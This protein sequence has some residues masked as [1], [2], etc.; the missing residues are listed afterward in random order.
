M[1]SDPSDVA[2]DLGSAWTLY[3]HDPDDRDWTLESYSRVCTVY[4]ASE[5]WGVQHRLSENNAICRGMW[6]L[7]REDVFP[8]WDDASNIEGGCVSFMVGKSDVSRVWQEFCE[9]MLCERMRADGGDDSEEINGI[10][11][12]PKNDFCIIKVWLRTEA[13]GGDPEALRVDRTGIFTSNRT[14]IANDK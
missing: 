8:C 5:Y 2:D 12:S 4:R 1:S 6:F 3:F 14:K 7:M 9:K 10:S 13:L 11:V